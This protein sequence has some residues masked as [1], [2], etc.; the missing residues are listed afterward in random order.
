[1]PSSAAAFETLELARTAGETSFSVTLIWAIAVFAV[2][3]LAAL[4]HSLSR[5]DREDTTE[6]RWP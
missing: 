4:L 1:M 3:A 6:L 5:Y 2:V